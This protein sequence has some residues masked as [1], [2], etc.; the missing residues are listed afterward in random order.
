M[1]LRILQTVVRTRAFS[2][3]AIQAPASSV[4]SRVRNF[5]INNETLKD[6]GHIEPKQSLSKMQKELL[7]Q[8]EEVDINYHEFKIRDGDLTSENEPNLIPF[9]EERRVVGCICHEDTHHISYLLLYKGLTTRCKCGHWF[10]LV[11]FNEYEAARDRYWKK[12]E[13]E[14]ENQKLMNQLKDAEAELQRLLDAS[15]DMT[16]SSP[17]SVAMLDKLAIQWQAYKEAYHLIRKKI[18]EACITDIR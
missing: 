13:H 11:D 6:D 9:D 4:Y 15:K 3:T 2:S 14:P 1:A 12:I 5:I 8:I 17:G 7:Q 10:K 16:E 18:D